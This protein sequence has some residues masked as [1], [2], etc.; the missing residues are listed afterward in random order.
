MN[1]SVAVA[2]TWIYQAVAA[3]RNY[4]AV[5]ATRLPT[6]T[7]GCRALAASSLLCRFQTAIKNDKNI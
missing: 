5:A 6:T 3:T 1:T 7:T 2:A 4:K